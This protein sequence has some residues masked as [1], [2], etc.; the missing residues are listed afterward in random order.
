MPAPIVDLHPYFSTVAEID[1]VINWQT[2]F[3]NDHPV[4]LDIGCGRGK[5]LFDSTVARPE[6]NWLGVELDFSEGRRGAKRIAK[7]EL[8]NGRVLGGDAREFLIKHV[9]PHSVEAAHVYFPDPWWK[10]RH[11]KRRLFT[12]EFADLLANVVKHGGHVHSWSDVEEYFGIISALMNHHPEFEPL[13]PAP[14]P[15]GKDDADY[16]TGFHRSRKKAGCTIY[17][18]LWRRR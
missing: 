16:L 13:P 8:P 5:F 9:E 6:T 2:F 17:R 14:E 1:G 3:G 18:G 15:E 4:E 12:D 10:T 7:R 11:K